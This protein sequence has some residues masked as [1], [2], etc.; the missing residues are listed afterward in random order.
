M[1]LQLLAPNETLFSGDVELISGVSEEGSFGMLP[2]HLPAVMQLDTAPLKID[3]GE[4][5]HAFAVYG[6]FLVKE[7]DESLRVLTQGAKGKDELVEVDIKER[8]DEIEAKLEAED[9][10]ESERSELER[11]LEKAQTDLMVVQGEY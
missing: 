7:R 9:I 10:D 8:I 2:R 5:E 1:E 6:G 3:T 4:S 11:A